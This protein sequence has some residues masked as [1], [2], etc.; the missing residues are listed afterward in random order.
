MQHHL[1]LSQIKQNKKI[2]QNV[3]VFISFSALQ[4]AFCV[5]RL[6]SSENRYIYAAAAATAVVV[7]YKIYKR[8]FIKSM[9]IICNILQITNQMSASLR[10]LKL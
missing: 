2:A 5:Q 4:H 10:R 8:S 6:K 9:I 7:E 1:V 3:S